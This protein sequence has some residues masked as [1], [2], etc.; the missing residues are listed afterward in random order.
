MMVL[1]Q[2]GW[3]MEEIKPEEKVEIMLWDW[4]KTK[5]N[6]IV[7]EVYFNRI[8]KLNA[9]VFT[10][11]GINKKPDFLIK[12]DMGYGIKYIAV[13]IKDNNRSAN[14]YDSSKILMYYDNYRTNK[15]L[16]YIN[17]KQISI[18]F[19]VIA[20]QGSIKS[21][22]F[23]ED[24]ELRIE[25]NKLHIGREKQVACGNEPEYEW[26]GTSQFLRTIFS[27]FRIYRKEKKIIKSG[28]PGL[29]ILTSKISLIQN[30]K[31]V[32]EFI[33]MNQPHIFIMN[34]NNYNLNYKIKWGCRYW[35]I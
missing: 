2:G 6:D 19:F 28:G 15:T 23:N 7:E 11:S 21:K 34:Y 17:E 31:R 24:R 22:L 1:N 5:S 20:T 18:D 25:S 32:P 26:N 33:N 14:V 8:N 3:K 12:I 27:N 16:Y 30:K 4:L 35:R 10:T 29:G 9:P 13:E